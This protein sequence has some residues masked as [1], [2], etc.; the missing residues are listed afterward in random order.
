MNDLFYR[1]GRKKYSAGSRK[2]FDNPVKSVNRLKNAKFF[3]G[4]VLAVCVVLLLVKGFVFALD[5]IGES[6]IEELAEIHVV[7][8]DVQLS[9]LDN[10]NFVPATSGQGLWEKDT[11]RTMSNSRAVVALFDGT[12]L[13][14]DESTVVKFEKLEQSGDNNVIDV[15]V[16]TGNVWVNTPQV[17]AG[18]TEL[19]VSTKYFDTSFNNSIV[20][21]TS[22]LPEYVRVISGLVNVDMKNGENTLSEFQLNAGQQIE[23]TN[24]SFESF[25]EG[26][27]VEVVSE[28]DRRFQL[29]QWYNWN[30]SED[31]NPSYGYNDAVVIDPSSSG[32]EAILFDEDLNGEFVAETEDG[33]D[34][35]IQPVFTSHENGEV[36][37]GEEIIDITGTVPANTA[38]VMIISYEDGPNR[39]FKYVLKGFEAG[40]RDFLYRAEYGANLIEGE[41]IY[42]AVA[43]DER[44]QESLPTELVLNY[45][46]AEEEEEVIDDKPKTQ[47]LEVDEYL[48]P[49]AEI[50]TVNDVTFTEGFVLDERKGVIEGT[51]G[52]WAESVFVNGFELTLYEAN[53]GNFRYILSPGFENVEAGENLIQVFGVDASGNR[54]LVK[55][56]IID[57]QYTE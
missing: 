9:S 36:V 40:D 4:I 56:F 22:N 27:N 48:S 47:T 29:S 45:V 2:V 16:V 1:S 55:E 6:S 46:P 5:K 17:L 34:P 12:R 39:P 25:V 32:E 11:I 23:L 52:T 31:R 54:S 44:G 37:E 8:G 51:I 30:V 33:V 7:A 3:F 43:I 35:S 28:I 38:N 42:E 13:R 19:N 10:Q 18:N 49:L 24:S 21:L 15:E 14:M 41:N 50:L 53:S 20:A 57:Y 26:E